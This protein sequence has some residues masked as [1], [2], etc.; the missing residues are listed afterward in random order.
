MAARQ[1]PVPILPVPI[2]TAAAAAAFTPSRRR[3]FARWSRN[4]TASLRRAVQHVDPAHLEVEGHLEVPRLD[5]LEDP[6]VRLLGRAAQRRARGGE[7]RPLHEV[8]HG[9]RRAADDAL[10]EGGEAEHLLGAQHALLERQLLSELGQIV[11]LPFEPAVAAALLGFAL[12]IPM[13]GVGGHGARHARA[14]AE[15]VGERAAEGR[16]RQIVIG[17]AC[18]WHEQVAVRH[19]VVEHRDVGEQ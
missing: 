6:L 16:E 9:W 2:R 12:L 4:G 18:E 13:S 14:R 8:Q 7:L 3:A 17:T 11:K 10:K 1:Q 15:P 5:Q 19:E